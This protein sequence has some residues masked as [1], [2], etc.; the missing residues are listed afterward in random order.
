RKN[1]QMGHGEATG[2][3]RRRS[4]PAAAETVPAS[5]GASGN[6]KSI[7]FTAGGRPTRPGEDFRVRLRLRKPRYPSPAPIP[8]ARVFPDDTCCRD[9]SRARMQYDLCYWGSRC[10]IILLMPEDG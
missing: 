7:A 8:G 10:S 9:C 2:D 4:E 5:V 1:A 6:E 3:R